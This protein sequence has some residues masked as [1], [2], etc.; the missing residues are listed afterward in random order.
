MKS[1][2]LFGSSAHDISKI[3]EAKAE[4]EKDAFPPSD[5]AATIPR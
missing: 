5:R 3:T 4:N 1:N 2:V